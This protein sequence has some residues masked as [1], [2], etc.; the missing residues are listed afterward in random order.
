MGWFAAFVEAVRKPRS[1]S[2]VM[3][4]VVLTTEIAR[5]IQRG[6]KPSEAVYRLAAK[7][8]G[9]D[10]DDAMMDMFGSGR[11]DDSARDH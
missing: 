4:G 2:T 1:P 6:Q 8:L 11:R 9:L 5:A 7:S 3:E 10:R